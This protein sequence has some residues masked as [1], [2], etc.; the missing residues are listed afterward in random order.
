[1]KITWRK[2]AAIE[3]TQQGYTV[4]PGLLSREECEG[5]AGL[6]ADGKLFRGRIDMAQY[7]FGRG[8]YQYFRD[9]LPDLVRDLRHAL[10]P[11]LAGVANEWAEMLG[12]S[13]FPPALDGLLEECRL[14][15]QTRPTPLLLRYRAGDYNCLHQDLYG[16]IAFPF[17]VVCFLSEPGRDYEGGEFLLV[18]QAPRAQAM[19]RAL[20][21]RQGDGL[22]ITTRHRPAQGKRGYYKVNARHGVSPVT[23]GE[24]WTLGIIFHNAK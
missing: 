10:Y 2:D 1:M 14:H 20:R 21:Q 12:L 8:E 13:G 6:Y 15:G 7:R 17:Q 5:T 23:E 19:G 9:P 16:E 4:L 3:L 18:E 24:R 11:P 22:V